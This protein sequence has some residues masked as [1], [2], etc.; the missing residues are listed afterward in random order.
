MEDFKQEFEDTLVE[1]CGEV[2]RTLERIKELVT[3]LEDLNEVEHVNKY[4]RVNP[5][6]I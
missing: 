6:N 2:N 4:I 5:N 3:E 1:K